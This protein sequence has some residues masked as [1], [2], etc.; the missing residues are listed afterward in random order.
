M[1]GLLGMRKDL[2]FTLPSDFYLLSPVFP[3]LFFPSASQ[4]QPS[5]LGPVGLLRRA[6][7]NSLHFKKL[8][9]PPGEFAFEL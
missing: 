2:A 5:G 3:F 6:L 8:T 1:P 4:L 9:R 7:F